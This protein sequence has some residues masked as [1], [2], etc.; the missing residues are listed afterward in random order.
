VRELTAAAVHELRGAGLAAEEAPLLRRTGRLRDSTGLSV[1]ERRANLSG[2]FAL[3]AGAAVSPEAVVVLVDD[4][5]TTG[6]TL[7]EAAAVLTVGRGVGAPPVLAAVVA[8]TPRR[9]AAAPSGGG[10]RQPI[11]RLSGRGSRD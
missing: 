11:G 6:A 5:V 1:A 10:T 7:T 3:V 8:A 9:N 2:T 4:V